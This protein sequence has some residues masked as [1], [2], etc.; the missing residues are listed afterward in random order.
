[1]ARP[2]TGIQG[3]EAYRGLPQRTRTQR[4]SQDFDAALDQALLRQTPRSEAP[5]TGPITLSRHAE[6]R[7]A[8][9]GIELSD[10]LL[11]TLEGAVD[12]LAAKGAKE[13]LV[14]TEDQ[15][16]IVGVPKRTVITVMDR[17]EALGQVFT[18]I[19]STFVAS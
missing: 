8:S 4:P 15:A 2:L 11:S 12:Q 18:H 5:A 1:M 16:F 19:D 13:S 6:A 10:E 17:S 9:R 14:L 7:L 3:V